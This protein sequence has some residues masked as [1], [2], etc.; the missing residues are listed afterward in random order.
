MRLV[1]KPKIAEHAADHG[2]E[3]VFGHRLLEAL[4]FHLQDQILKRLHFRIR[5]GKLRAA[6]SLDSNILDDIRPLHQHPVLRVPKLAVSLIPPLH[7]RSLDLRYLQRAP[8]RVPRVPRLV[9]RATDQ[10]QRRARRQVVRR[11]S[12]KDMRREMN[13]RICRR[14]QAVDAIAVEPAQPVQHRATGPAV[15]VRETRTERLHLAGE[16]HP[17]QH[18][19]DR[20]LMCRAPL[21]AVQS[22]QHNHRSL[23]DFPYTIQTIG[24]P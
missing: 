13:V 24:S 12:D 2:Q 20:R 3:Q 16:V 23:I 14:D 22:L 4:T 15:S 11:R 21:R 19:V 8:R 9:V 17:D 10:R 18:G 7:Q 5:A 1:P 6:Q